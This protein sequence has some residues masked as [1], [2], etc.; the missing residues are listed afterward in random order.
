MGNYCHDFFPEIA[1]FEGRKRELYFVFA[2]K[3]IILT[4]MVE[5]LS[6][7]ISTYQCLSENKKFTRK[8]CAL[9]CPVEHRENINK[10]RT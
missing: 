2:V 1:H 5:I 3:D 4:S 10:K 7:S 6:T 8:N 9:R